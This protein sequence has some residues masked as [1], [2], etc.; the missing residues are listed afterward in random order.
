L[1][2]NE[3]ESKSLMK[4]I[5]RRLLEA[6]KA[7]R[8]EAAGLEAGGEELLRQA[9]AERDALVTQIQLETARQV[10]ELTREMTARIEDEREVISRRAVE[11]V[12]RLRTEAASRRQ[13]AIDRV[14]A[15]VL[16]EAAP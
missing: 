11:A 7:G 5:L 4:D 14:V 8:Q 1:R 3:P 12:Q 13:A 6:E 16:G 2:A 9:A 10:D 15:I